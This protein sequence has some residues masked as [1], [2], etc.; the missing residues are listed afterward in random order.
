MFIRG[1]RVPIFAPKGALSPAVLGQRGK[2]SS[3]FERL[4]LKRLSFLERNGETKIWL[5]APKEEV[6]G[7]KQNDVLFVSYLHRW[8]IHRYF[9]GIC[10]Y[11]DEKKYSNF[12]ILQKNISV[13]SQYFQKI[14]TVSVKKILI[15][16]RGIF[17]KLS[18][19][20][21]LPRRRTSF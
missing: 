15:L 2:Q 12:I 14:M 1:L 11:S 3:G 13:S 21:I 18:L 6:M 17:S 7:Y 4:P 20:W 19:Q 5:K 16:L 8:V 9:Y 10:V